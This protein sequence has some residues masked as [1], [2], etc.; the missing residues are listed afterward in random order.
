[1]LCLQLHVDDTER[2]DAWINNRRFY[3][4]MR[5]KIGPVPAIASKNS[6]RSARLEVPNSWAPERSTLALLR[7]MAYNAYIHQCCYK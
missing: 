4:G 1:M 6:K 2:E 5:E 3:Q 7:L